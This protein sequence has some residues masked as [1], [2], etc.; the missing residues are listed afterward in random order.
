MWKRGAFAPCR[1]AYCA[2]CYV[3][4]GEKLFKVRE[5]LDDDGVPLIDKEENRFLRARPGDMFMVPFQCDVCHFR[6]IQK[7]D[8]WIGDSR[9]EETLE[10]IRRAN[11]DAFWARESST[12][13][14]NLNVLFRAHLCFERLNLNSTVH[15]LGPFPLYDSF[16][17]LP[18]IA[19]LDK[20]LDKGKYEEFVQ[21]ET[22]RKMR[23]AITNFHQASASGLEDVIASYERKN[24]WISKVPTHSFWFSRFMTGIH[25]RVGEV[26]RQDW[27]IPIE[28][29]QYID[30]ALNRLW[31]DAVDDASRKK[32]AEMGVWFVVQFCT[33]LRGE[34]ML[35]VEFTGTADSLKFLEEES[36]PHFLLRIKGRTKGF[37]I[38]GK[39]FEI[40]CVARTGVSGLRPGRWMRRLVHWIQKEGR[41]HGKLLQRRLAVPRLIEFEEDFFDVLESVQ[42]STTLISDK[43]DLR[44]EAGIRRTIRRG[45][46]SHAINMEIDENLL[47]SVNRWRSEFGT[48]GSKVHT[49]NIVD[50]YAQLDTLKPVFLRFSKAL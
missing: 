45:L 13:S 12:V 15:H 50:H 43:I 42:S 19:V 48:D 27:P 14:K 24:L 49:Y 11:L 1:Q 47:R 2:E 28:V 7:R 16:G 10:Y 32:I 31:R 46:T 41:N 44:E 23:S 37:L 17:M 4:R 33:G 6:N 22:F 34:E 3:P 5:T 35:L 9:D 18:A 30:K 38:S 40:P 29:V 20:S 25:K 21:W 36:D 8:P 39:G 26:V